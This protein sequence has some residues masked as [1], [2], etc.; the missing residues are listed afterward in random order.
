MAQKVFAGLLLLA[1]CLATVSANHPAS[2][3]MRG[4]KNRRE[5]IVDDNGFYLG[6]GANNN[7]REASQIYDLGGPIVNPWINAFTQP[8]ERIGTAQRL[9]AHGLGGY[10]PASLGVAGAGLGMA[11]AGLGMSGAGFAGMGMGMGMGAGSFAGQQPVNSFAT[12]TQQQQQQG[13]GGI[14]LNVLAQ[15]VA[16]I[17]GQQNQQPQQQQHQ[18]VQVQ[19]VQQPIQIQQ[20]Q[21]MP[22][23]LQPFTAVFLNN[24]QSPL[25]KV[26]LPNDYPNGYTTI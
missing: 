23:K 25:F 6:G 16:Q 12:N 9:G 19:T 1:I 4:L 5:V 24:G 13:S 18:S 20:E 14:D 22:A 3:L 10:A 26:G 2:P 15:L 8:L 17:V 7:L 21:P 11:G